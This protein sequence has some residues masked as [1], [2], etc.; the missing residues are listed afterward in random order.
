MY[1]CVSYFSL[2]LSLSLSLSFSLSLSLS[3]SLSP[4]PHISKSTDEVAGKRLVLFSYGSGLASAMYSVRFAADSSPKKPNLAAIVE[5][6]SDIPTRLKARK[7]LPPV[8]F[9]RIMKLR[10]ETHHLAPYTPVSDVTDMFPGSFY[11]TGVDSKHRR[12]YGRVSPE[13]KTL[14]ELHSPVREMEFASL[15]NGSNG[16]KAC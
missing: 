9:E 12:A 2:S 8:E 4:P 1:V 7:T 11:L 16:V 6:L 13:A 10:E 15:A 3:L 14:A 5:G